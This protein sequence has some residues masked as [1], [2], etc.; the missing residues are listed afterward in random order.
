MNKN[1][2]I[3]TL[4]AGVILVLGFSFLKQTLTQSNSIK[5][6]VLTDLTSGGAY[7]GVSTKIGIDL[8]VKEL[9]TEN[10]H[11][12]PIYEDYR[13]NATIAA[14]AAQKLVNVDKVEGLYAEFNP[15]A[16][17]AGSV[18]RDKNV[19]YL[20]DSAVESPL[21]ESS[22]AY[23]TYLDFRKGC[24]L[25]ASQFKN[26]GIVSVGVLQMKLEAGELCSEGIESVYGS[27][28]IIETYTVGDQDFR[29]QVLKLKS[30]NV[31]AIINAGFEGDVINT[32]SA[33]KVNTI[34]VPFGT[35]TD[36]MSIKVIA[37]YPEQTKGSISF[38]F[39]DIDQRII[40]K[41]VASNGGKPLGNNYAAVL[42]YVHM[43][44]LVRSLSVCNHDIQCAGSKLS[45]SPK[46]EN[47]GF[48]KF[49]NRIADLDILVK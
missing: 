11:V 3:I 25:L 44:Q 45:E 30:K 23:K 47:I 27:N 42:G 12:I 24:A 15:A 10:I 26:K 20:Y 7:W 48:Q 36:S 17:A 29:T 28:A 39:K 16:I 40:D 22:N 46:D 9:A 33:M 21:L 18:V 49:T 32:L 6:G 14:T 8:A 38:G 37:L 31:G 4:I 43:K 1:K 13:F 35:V 5:I 41:L 19:L 2:L 34:K